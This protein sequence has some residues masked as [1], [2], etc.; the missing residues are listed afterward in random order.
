MGSED[1]VTADA[2]SSTDQHVTGAPETGE[3]ITDQA[4]TATTPA[5]G[6]SNSGVNATGANRQDADA[7]EDGEQ[8]G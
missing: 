2:G 3:F 6:S 8:A 7:P 4:P 5:H 1:S